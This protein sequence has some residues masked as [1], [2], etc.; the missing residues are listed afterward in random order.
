MVIFVDRAHFQT[1]PSSSM[2]G[3]HHFRQPVQVIHRSPRV[4][5]LSQ[6]TCDSHWAIQTSHNHKWDSPLH[7]CIRPMKIVGWSSPFYDNGKLNHVLSTACWKTNE[8]LLYLARPVLEDHQN[9]RYWPFPYSPSFNRQLLAFK[10]I[11]N[12]VLITV[13]YWPL[14]TIISHHLPLLTTTLTIINHH[15]S[16][17]AAVASIGCPPVLGDLNLGILGRQIWQIWQEKWDY[18]HINY[19]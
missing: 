12:H 16:P 8:P 13:N 5:G 1:H 3:V 6:F 11:V 14:L 15:C 4:G 7:D 19:T 10:T 2:V 17:A 9:R 18:V